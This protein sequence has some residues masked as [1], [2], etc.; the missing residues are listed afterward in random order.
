[1]QDSCTPQVFSYISL[2]HINKDYEDRFL[3]NGLPQM[4]GTTGTEKFRAQ[5]HWIICAKPFI[6][7]SPTLAR[8]LIDDTTTFRIILF[9]Y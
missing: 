3:P 1:M 2:F 7:E 9:I 8:S 4:I 5:R 6:I